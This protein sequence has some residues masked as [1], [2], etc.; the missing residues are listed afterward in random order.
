MEQPKPTVIATELTGVQ[1]LAVIPLSII[2]S[3]F[4]KGMKIQ[5]LGMGIKDYL[6]NLK[7]LGT[8]ASYCAYASLRHFFLQKKHITAIKRL[9]LAGSVQIPHYVRNFS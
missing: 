1:V 5:V 2:V 7:S 8:H 3:E 6:L 4:A 9:R